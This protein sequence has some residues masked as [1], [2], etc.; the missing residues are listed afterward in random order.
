MFD[1][2][3]FNGKMGLHQSDDLIFASKTKYSGHE[4]YK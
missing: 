4:K 2:I 3:L 1:I